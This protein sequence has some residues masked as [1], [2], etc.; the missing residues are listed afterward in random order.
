MRGFSPPGSEA[1]HPNVPEREAPRTGAG[2]A[3]CDQFGYGRSSR[4]KQVAGGWPSLCVREGFE[5]ALF[6][7]QGRAG[8]FARSNTSSASIRRSHTHE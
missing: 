5:V 3:R 6:S 4:G 7:P 8:S 2:K 1:R